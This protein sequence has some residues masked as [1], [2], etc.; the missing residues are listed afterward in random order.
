MIKA[1]KGY[2]RHKEDKNH[3]IFMKKQ[4]ELEYFKGDGVGVADIVNTW[5]ICDGKFSCRAIK[6]KVTGQYV[7]EDSEPMLVRKVYDVLDNYE[8]KLV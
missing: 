2:Y 8:N 3:N 4:K 1:E 7:L 5:E 6:S